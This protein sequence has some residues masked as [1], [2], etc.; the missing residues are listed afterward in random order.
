[1]TAGAPGHPFHIHVNPFQIVAIRNSSN[2]NV[3]VDGE[4]DDPQ[5]ANLKGEWRDTLFVKGGYTIITRSRYRRYM[6]DF[7]LH[8]HILDREDRGMMLNV[9]VAIPDGAGG[10]A[11][12]HP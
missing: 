10:V 6:G 5:Y 8:C 2:M 4:P 1:M 9:R 12:G 11:N 3:S 7:V